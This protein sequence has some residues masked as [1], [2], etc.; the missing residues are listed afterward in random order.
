MNT[1]KIFKRKSDADAARRLA[2]RFM[3]GDTTPAEERRLFAFFAMA[4]EGS[5]PSDLEAMRPMMAWYASLA[6][7]APRRSRMRAVAAAA[8]VVAVVAA[9]AV[10]LMPSRSTDDGLYACYQGSYIIRNGRRV[11]DVR[12]IYSYLQSAER[13]ADSLAVA[14]D[15][16]IAADIDPGA[17]IVEQALKGIADREL[18][19]SIMNEIEKL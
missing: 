7:A 3:A 11:S 16:D 10:A 15:I 19:N 1:P 18:A 14:A 8:A 4:P 2:D 9:T 13:T 5:L 12:E 6:P 17:D